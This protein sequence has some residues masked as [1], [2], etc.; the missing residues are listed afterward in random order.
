MHTDT[1][2]AAQWWAQSRGATSANWIANYQRSL[3]SRQ[4]DVISGIMRELAP[5]EVLEVGCHCGP[6]LV[7]LAQE[8]PTLRAI[9]V[10]INAEAVAAG[11]QWLTSAGL[12]SRV[13][14]N[15]G[16]FPAVTAGI[17]DGAFDVVLSCYALAYIAPVDLEAAL[18]EMGRLA[19]R[20]VVLAEPQTDQVPAAQSARSLS[21]YTEWT[22]RYTAALPWVG[23]LRDV[24]CRTVP[25]DPPVDKLNAVLV[26]TRNVA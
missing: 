17:A 16:R 4:R 22:H 11:R 24:T 15:A 20:A 8:H 6:N 7:R 2:E 26:I 10:D 14:L 23:S 5:A 25:V 21:G 19:A 1:L 18:Y 9:G 3:H 13:Q 12:E